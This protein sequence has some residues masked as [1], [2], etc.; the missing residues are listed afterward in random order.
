MPPTNVLQVADPANEPMQVPSNATYVPENP[1]QGEQDDF[2]ASLKAFNAEM[3]KEFY[4][5]PDEPGETAGVEV[6][7]T[8]PAPEVPASA[9]EAEKDDPAVARGLDRLIAREIEIKSREDR[10]TQMEAQAKQSMAELNALKGLKST[11]ELQDLA[12]HS[13]TETMQ[14]LGQDP[15]TAVR[16]LL[17]ERLVATGKQVPQELKEFARDA[18]YKREM[19]QLRKQLE[20]K[21]RAASQNSYF[22]A[23]Q[24]G[25]REYVKTVGDTTPTVKL[26]AKVNPDRVHS[27]IMEEITKD[28]QIRVAQDPTAD[29]ITYAE[30]A[31]RV[32]ARW[33][34]LKNVIQTNATDST[35]LA[36]GAKTNQP[37]AAKPPAKPLHTWQT[38]TK[39]KEL[40]D[41]GIQ[42]ALKEFNKVEAARKAR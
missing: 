14:A 24:L 37:P 15:D 23:V 10:V 34:E 20:E 41:L 9:P 13:L 21:D 33:A 26:V 19:A 36:P 29:L 3:E 27:E 18:T 31:K 42:E 25:A 12:Q 22:N 5:K 4:A 32:E 30:A 6:E 35:K 11:K 16:L 28:A 17:A 7:S 40:E 8:D 39:G 38:P 1:L 2:T